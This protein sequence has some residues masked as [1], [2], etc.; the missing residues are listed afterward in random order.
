MNTAIIIILVILIVA[1]L[2]GIGVGLYF[3]LRKPAAPTGPSGTN[4]PTPPTPTPNPTPGPTPTP[5]PTPGPTPRTPFA[6]QSSTHAS[7]YIF[8]NSSY[9]LG[10][11]IQEIPLLYGHSTSAPCINYSWRV[12]SNFSFNGQIIAN[13]LVT[14]SNNVDI[15]TGNQAPTTDFVIGVGGT[16]GD[17]LVLL[18]VLG[19]RTLNEVSWTYNPTNKT[20]CNGVGECIYITGS[21]V[22]GRAFTAGDPG[23]QWDNVP[24]PRSCT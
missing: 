24:V 14:N 1:I 15:G 5:N 2:V 21:G 13:A 22:F 18:G 6:I 10:T 16:T 11:P 8:I 23:F 17:T 20:W 9:P 7:N 12:E 19:N 3:L 4:Q